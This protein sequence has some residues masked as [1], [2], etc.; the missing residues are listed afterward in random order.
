MLQSLLINDE[1]IQLMKIKGHYPLD[2]FTP[3][4]IKE[5]KMIIKILQP[6][7]TATTDLSGRL[8]ICKIT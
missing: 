1:Y 8:K 2:C 7:D 4:E 5:I 6:Y 3:H